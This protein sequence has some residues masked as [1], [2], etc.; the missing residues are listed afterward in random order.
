MPREWPIMDTNDE[1]K[2]AGS[3][4]R[5]IESSLSC[6]HVLSALETINFK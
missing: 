1:E 4:A 5:R 3:N 6:E 2:V